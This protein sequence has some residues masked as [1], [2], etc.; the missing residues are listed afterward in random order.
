MSSTSIM[1]SAG[2]W[3]RQYDSNNHSSDTELRCI[4]RYKNDSVF[5]ALTA[6]L[7]FPIP[8]SLKYKRITSAK[9]RYYCKYWYYQYETANRETGME[10]APFITDGQALYTLTGANY[11]SKGQ[12]GAWKTVEP[13]N[14]YVTYPCERT[15]DVTDLLTDRKSVV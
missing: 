7:Q 11:E 5:G 12:L 2:T 1:M 13:F 4:R 10:V 9:I 3:I 15:A 6:V 14:R 8:S